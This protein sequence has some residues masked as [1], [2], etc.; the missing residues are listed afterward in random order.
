MA[1]QPKK[2]KEG[3]MKAW[4][5]AWPSLLIIGAI[6]GAGWGA[7]EYM[8]TYTKKA[9]LQQVS[10]KIEVVQVQVQ[11]VYDV[12]IEQLTI[13]RDRLIRKANKTQQELQDLKDIEREL[14]LARKM[15]QIK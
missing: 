3:L 15:R 10:Q 13:Q 7:S 14:E 12:R 9:E 5:I 11:S 4:A 8:G 2:E 1:K 6:A